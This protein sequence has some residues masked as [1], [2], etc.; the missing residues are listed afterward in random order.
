MINYLVY[1]C[2]FKELYYTEIKVNLLQNTLKSGKEK[3]KVAYESKIYFI[4]FKKF[5]GLT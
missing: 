2:E 3:K 1:K 4:H 5:L